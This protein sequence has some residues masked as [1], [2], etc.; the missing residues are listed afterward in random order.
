M[1][2]DVF[3][4]VIKG[5]GVSEGG[6]AELQQSSRGVNNDFS[7]QKYDAIIPEQVDQQMKDHKLKWNYPSTGS[8][9][10]PW[11]EL[12]KTG[13]GERNP[14]RR[15]ACSLSHYN[16]WKR[17]VD[18][19]RPLLI[20][21]HDSSFIHKFNPDFILNSDFG[22]VGINSPIQATFAFDRYDQMI[23]QRKE[24]LQ[25]V[26]MLA[27]KEVP[28]GLAGNSAYL[29]KPTAAKHLIELCHKYG[30]WPNDAIMC[31]QLCNFLGVSRTYYTRVQGLKST[32]TL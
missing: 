6:F 1:I 9:L 13:Y 10:D 5:H 15:I 24:E 23:Q 18:T 14:L 3:A 27:S 11:T 22:V 16:L 29:I 20:L 2:M 19:N 8:V 30:L 17:S 25:P 4:I 26:P 12:R 21:E 7:V 31:Q 32:T 28:Q